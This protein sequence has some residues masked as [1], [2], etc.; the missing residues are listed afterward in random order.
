MKKKSVLEAIENVGKDKFYSDIE[1]VKPEDIKLQAVAPISYVS[2]VEQNKRAKAKFTKMIDEKTKNAQGLDNKDEDR[3]KHMNKSTGKVDLKIDQPGLKKMHLDE[4]LFT[5]DFDG[6]YRVSFRFDGK[7]GVVQVNLVKADSEQ[8][9]IDKL[10]AYKQKRYP[11]RELEIFGGQPTYNGEV[12]D[13]KKRGYPV[14]GEGIANKPLSNLKEALESTELAEQIK[15]I[16]S[17]IKSAYRCNSLEELQNIEFKAFSKGII[18][19]ALRR[20]SIIGDKD[21]NNITEEDFDDIIDTIVDIMQSYLEYAQERYEKVSKAEN[22]SGP[23]YEKVYNALR[24]SKYEIISTTNNKILIKDDD[25]VSPH[26]LAKLVINVTGGKTNG[27][28]L[29]GSWTS[30]NI[31]TPDGVEMRVGLLDD[32]EVGV[33]FNNLTESLKPIVEGFKE[34]LISLFKKKNLGKYIDISDIVDDVVT[35]YNSS[36]P[37]AD[38]RYKIKAES[39]NES[40]PNE[41]GELLIPIKEYAKSIVS[42]YNQ[43]KDTESTEDEKAFVAD[44]KALQDLVDKIFSEYNWANVSAPITEGVQEDDGWNEDEISELEHWGVLGQIADLVYEIKN[45]R[46]G[47]YSRAHTADELGQYIKDLAEQ[48]DSFGDEVIALGDTEDIEESLNEGRPSNIPP[49][50]GY[51]IRLENRGGVTAYNIYDKNRELEDS[52]FR[53]IEAA[54]EAIDKLDESLKQPLK[55]ATVVSNLNI[56]KPWNKA[57]PIFNKIKA[58]EDKFYSFEKMIDEMY[59]AGIEAQE[60]NDLLS[61]DVEFLE[62]ML[63]MD[64]GGK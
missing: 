10:R 44:L 51:L 25:T 5:E 54:K 57:V 21:T 12:N 7:D 53:S 29:G 2:A 23:A 33:K 11:D 24:N 63:Q 31:Y 22:A 20:N 58:N 13:L 32:G 41:V 52:G 16:K 27:S 18:N 4:S 14:I 8:E 62:G 49:Y 6:Y 36:T 59:P 46:M 61:Y 56:F 28:A 19:S 38:G 35:I 39:L 1:V 26:E 45:L 60:L 3:F 43:Y 34:K 37:K 50:K 9:A 17:D 47:Y 55:E 40:I 48:L 30:H 15:N 42:R 64:L